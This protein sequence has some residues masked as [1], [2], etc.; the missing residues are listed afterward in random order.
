MNPVN[1]TINPAYTASKENLDKV[2]ELVKKSLKELVLPYIEKS[3]C[4]GEQA[5]KLSIDWIN[6]Y[7]IKK[8]PMKLKRIEAAKFGIFMGKAYPD[9]PLNILSIISD[10][11]TWLYI[12]DD[13]IEKKD[14]AYIK[15]LHMR[16]LTIINGHQ[17]IDSDI[18]LTKGLFDIVR[19]LYKVCNSSVWKLRFQ[20]E[21]AIF[22]NGTLWQ[23]ANHIRMKIPSLKQYIK[24]RPDFSGTKWM[25]TFNELIS[26]IVPDKIF[27]N[28]DFQRLRLLGVNL[29]NWE[30]DL[31][32]S[33]KELLEQDLHNL[34]F[35]YKEHNNCDY[36][37]AFRCVIRDLKADLA[38]FEELA[39]R[40]PDDT[41]IVKKY[42]SAIKDWC[43][44]HHYWA[45]ESPRYKE[46]FKD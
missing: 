26:G 1:P 44:A 29:V 41:V 4:L 13:K 15:N 28:E 42:I 39:N 11:V 38:K 27:N 12:Y 17:L 37:E 31:L 34:V 6:K 14:M 21:A 36:E 24:W 19:R 10:F 22:C 9:A 2:K 46:Y 32:S 18:P 8:N 23:K 5:Q 40:V 45:K 3:S 20:S 7:Q 30:N 35:V 16:T 33:P 43:S 25:F